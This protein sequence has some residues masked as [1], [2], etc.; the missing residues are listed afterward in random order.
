MA[1][2]RY[3]EDKFAQLRKKAEK[4]VQQQPAKTSQL[5]SDMD[6]L[7]HELKVYQAEL[8][9]QNEELKNSQQELSDLY[10]KYED[11]YESAPFGYITL[12]TKGLIKEINKSAA[13]ML[14]KHKKNILGTHFTDFINQNW[15]DTFLNLQRTAGQTGDNKNV[16]I[17]IKSDAKSN[18][19]VH[20]NLIA[21]RNNK[22]EV[23]NW[24]LTLVDITTRKNYEK[25]LIEAREKAKESDR[26]KTTFLANMSHEIR[27]PMN[28]ILGF[29][30]L[31]KDNK[32][33]GTK[34]NK[35]IDIII[36]NGNHLLTIINDLIDISKI[37][38]GRIEIYQSRI[39]INE[40]LENMNI[41][42]KPETDE[43]GLKLSYHTPLPSQQATLITD[44]EKLHSIW[45]NL[46]KNAI[47]YTDEGYIDFGYQLEDNKLKCYV[48][49]SGV[50]ISEK[51]Q[52]SIFDHFV[53]VEK[54]TSKPQ[55][56]TGLGLA[57]A[58]AYVEILGGEISLDSKK[59]QGSRFT[60][61]IPYKP[62]ENINLEKPV[63]D[64]SVSFKERRILLVE[65][66]YASQEY[67][68]EILVDA[69]A[70]IIIA[71]TGKQG[72]EEVKKHTDLD[73]ALIDIGLPDL[74]GLEVIKQIKQIN[75]KILVLAQTAY[76]SNEDRNK[77][78]TAGA[79]DYIAKPINKMNLLQM[80]RKHIND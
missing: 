62:A 24:K 59:G 33:S 25:E 12:D 51:D 48:K 43:K 21:D 60:F 11:L 74:N 73:L 23:Y 31:L 55:E 29:A 6:E 52:E 69:N 27:T 26:L 76:A 63:A 49:D 79:D 16:E 4:L 71:E 22:T 66:D 18:L 77:C 5:P 7:L 67:I 38:T 13:G 78:I 40:E 41:F 64:S 61:T 56:G 10:Y 50:G 3:S 9:I 17:P 53:Q 20:I 68:K 1:T 28:G 36:Q 47:K 46:I 14:E 57:I 54:S 58:K 37:E 15:I 72:I 45:I 32:F 80:I 2:N 19:W 42:F 35:F 75:N 39:N 65:D 70:V 34:R 44:R 30:G 8:E